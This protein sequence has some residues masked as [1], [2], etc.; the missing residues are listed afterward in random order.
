MDPA[1]LEIFKT[2]GVAAPMVVLQFWLLS[3]CET[4]RQTMTAGFLAELQLLGSDQRKDMAR[5][6]DRQ[7]A[8]ISQVMQIGMNRAAQVPTVPPTHTGVT[9]PMP[10]PIATSAPPMMN[11]WRQHNAN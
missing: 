2:L 8:L 10:G 9:I 1:I 6:L 11:D 7:E 4:E 3:R 5:M